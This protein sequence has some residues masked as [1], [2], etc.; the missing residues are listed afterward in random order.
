MGDDNKTKGPQI[1]EFG[2]NEL[3]ATDEAGAKKFY[4]SL[5]GWTAEAF[6]AG[7]DYTLF[8]QG[9]TMVGGMMKCR[10]PEMPSHWLPY[11]VVEN[12]DTTAAKAAK[13]GAKIVIEPFDVPTVGRIAVFTDP[14]GAVMGI[15]KP[16]EQ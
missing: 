7:G 4:T 14:Q 3:V 5:F 16:L 1:G 8:K 12:V 6:G 9:E 11:V 10:K 13:S 2:W 15:F